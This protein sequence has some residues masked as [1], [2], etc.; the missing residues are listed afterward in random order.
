[1]GDKRDKDENKV[2]TI[3]GSH[4]FLSISNTADYITIN[5]D[6]DD[7]MYHEIHDFLIRSTFQELLEEDEQEQKMH[8]LFCRI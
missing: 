4:S 5:F 1:M 6:R 7:V 3:T 2:K 8:A